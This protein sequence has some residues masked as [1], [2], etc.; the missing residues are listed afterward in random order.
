M[1]AANPIMSEFNQKLKWVI[2][3]SVNNSSSDK[4]TH[5]RVFKSR[6]DPKALL[7]QEYREIFHSGRI[8]R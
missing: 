6:E 3:E 4:T 8:I 1:K 7:N 2:E 5:K